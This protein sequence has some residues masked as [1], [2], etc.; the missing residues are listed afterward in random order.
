MIA[1]T[2]VGS[3]LKVGGISADSR[4]P[5][6][7]LVPAPTKTMR[8]PLRRAVAIISTPTAI[9]SR[10]RW[11]AASI[12]R[13]SLIISFDDVVGGELVDAEGG[14]VDGF[15]RERLPLRAHRHQVRYNST[16]HGHNLTTS[17][18]RRLSDSSH[19]RAAAGRQLGRELRARPGAPAG[20]RGG[21]SNAGRRADAARPRGAGSRPDVGR[22]FA[23]VGR[24]RHRL[25][26]RASTGFSSSTAA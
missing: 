3:V 12:L 8:P 23:A 24:P 11:T 18:G 15:G 14:G 19:G 17:P 21:P 6:R 10:S 5:R 1:C 22:A 16:F 20:I 13:S 7:P 2:S 26:S 4:T 25:L 9:R